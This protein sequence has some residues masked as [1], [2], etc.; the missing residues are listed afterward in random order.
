M[1][2]TVV[3]VRRYSYEGSK[4]PERSISLPDGMPAGRSRMKKIV[5][6]E[7]VREL[8]TKEKSF[9]NR[10]DLAIFTAA[11]GDEVLT[12]HRREKADLI[13]MLLETPGMP[14][15]QLCSTI[16]ESKE[17]RTVSLLLICADASEAR[18][19]CNRC[20]VNEV[21]TLPL[22]TGLLLEKAQQ[23]LDISGRKSYRVL[24]NVKV[25]GRETGASFFC[26][27]ENISLT[28]ILIETDQQLA[29]GD[30]VS[31]SFSLSGT[32][33]DISGEVTRTIKPPLDSNL[34]RYGIR[35]INVTDRAKEAIEAFAGHEPRLPG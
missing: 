28:G 33:V 30:R 3:F 32:Q 10:T 31:C 9:L 27:S 8:L 35:F 13:I 4:G 26:K 23:F 21:F 15:E 17:L 16:R 2:N 12:L 1:E 11:S 7:E 20:R 14:A 29:Q 22:E 18:E 34:R 19:R 24:L 25:E 5:I 6:T